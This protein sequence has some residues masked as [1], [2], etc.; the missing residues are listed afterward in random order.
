MVAQTV[1]NLMHCGTPG[2][3][4]WVG[5]IPWRRA[6][7]TTPVCI[8]VCVCIYTHTYLARIYASAKSLQWCSVVWDPKD[9]SLPGASVYGI[10][11]A[12]ILEW[13]SLLQGIFLTQGLNLHLLHWQ[14]DSLPLEHHLGIY[15]HTHTHTDIWRGNLKTHLGSPL[16]F[17]FCPNPWK[18]LTAW[19]STDARSEGKVAGP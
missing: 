8:Y 15:T 17:M 10:L 1:K 12:S 3:D 7:L 4:P 5:K 2:F 9:S 19:A 11:Q 14:A 18:Y 16:S 6:W 13:V